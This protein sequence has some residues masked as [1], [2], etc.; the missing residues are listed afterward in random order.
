MPGTALNWSSVSIPRGVVYSLWAGVSVPAAGA[1]LT[2]HTDGTP[3]SVANPNAIHLGRTAEGVSVQVA[4][5]FEN[6]A[7]D[8]FSAPYR[9]IP[10]NEGMRISAALRQVLDFQV[11]Q[12]LTPLSTRATGTGYEE[13]AI[14]G[15]A[16]VTTTSVA[17]I[18]Q[19]PEDAT[20]FWVAHIYKAYN[21]AGVDFTV[22]RTADGQTA[23]T[24]EGITI[25][26]RA[27]GDQIGKI[28]KQVA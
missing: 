21:S 26:T 5:G 14:G 25:D 23:V 17:L 8:E 28:W 13:L 12:R 9:V 19:M 10:A 22:R 2:L 6:V 20:K 27:A 7:S 18:C 1:R 15:T 3:E 16:T 24:F 11:L 4:G